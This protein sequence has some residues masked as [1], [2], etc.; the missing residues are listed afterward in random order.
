LFLELLRSET[1]ASPDR[2]RRALEGLR[3]YQ[4]AERAPAQE[5]MPAVAERLG[6]TLRDYGGD[7]PP[8]LFVP[9]LINPPNLLDLSEEKSLLRWL[10]RRGVRPLLLDWGWDVERRRDLSVAGHVEEI[11]LPLLG[12]IDGR[13]ALVGYCLGGT[14]ALAAA[15]LA[16]V[17]SVVTI[18]APWRFSGF[19]DEARAEL[20]GLWRHGKEAARQLGVFPMELL[21]SAFWALDPARTVGK[22]ERFA[23]IPCGS[24]EAAAFVSLEDWANDGPPI[25]EGAAREMFESFFEADLP[26]RGEWLAGGTRV[27]P[28]ALSAPLLNIVSTTDRIVPSASAVPAGER[29]D[30]AQGHVGMVV[31]SRAREALWE[32]LADWLSRR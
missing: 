4:E 17:R 27:D 23:G 1:A 26:G 13:P 9:S 5:P 24:A 21:Q 19:S 2:M 18:A 14:M 10:S 30:L 32:P 20:A 6:A 11:V 16:P 3:R 8:V 31:G 29:L 22:F 7:G 28:A 12:A 25:P 15:A